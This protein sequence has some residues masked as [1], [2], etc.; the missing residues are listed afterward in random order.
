[1]VLYNSAQDFFYPN[2]Q[3]KH[4]KLID[5]YVY[6]YHTDEYLVIPTWPESMADSLKS[7][8]SEQNALSR[9]A[10]VLSYSNSG[11]RQVTVSLHLHR[12]MLEDTIYNNSKMKVDLDDDYIDTLIKR[13]QSIALPKYTTSSK[14]VTPPMVAIRFGNEIFVKGIV[15]GGINLNYEKPILSNGKYAQ[16]TV[17]FTI[18]EIDPYDAE[19]VQLEGSFR[20]ITRTFKKGIYK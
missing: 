14:A 6:L 8:F 12:S 4:F 17:S 9:S 11:P 15:N 7:T 3:G 2:N 20:G 10:P 19:S 13:L 18:T 16:V 1:M 5:N